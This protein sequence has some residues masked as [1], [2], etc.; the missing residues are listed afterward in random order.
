MPMLIT[1][2]FLCVFLWIK[3]FIDIFFIFTFVE[4][5]YLFL[6]LCCDL[7]SETGCQES[8]AKVVL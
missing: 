7:Q 4:V 3:V 1:P 2:S 8:S 6:M 5:L